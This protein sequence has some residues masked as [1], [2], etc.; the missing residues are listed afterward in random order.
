VKV[1]VKTPRVINLEFIR[2][3]AASSPFRFNLIQKFPGSYGK[4]G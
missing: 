2:K 1:E 3:Y 4:E